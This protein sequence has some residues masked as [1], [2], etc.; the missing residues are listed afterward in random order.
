MIID[1]K[2]YNINSIEYEMRFHRKKKLNK[3]EIWLRNRAFL[4]MHPEGSCLEPV[5]MDRVKAL[6]F[7]DSLHYFGNDTDRY[8]YNTFSA[9]ELELVYTSRI[10]RYSEMVMY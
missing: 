3:F 4:R 5:R 1:N 2:D 7:L 6:V 9:D 8:M 10:S